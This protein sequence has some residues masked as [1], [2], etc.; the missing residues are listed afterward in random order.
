[1]DAQQPMEVNDSIVFIDPVGRSTISDKMFG[2]SSNLV[3]EK[4]ID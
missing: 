2:T 1:M 4:N 3:P